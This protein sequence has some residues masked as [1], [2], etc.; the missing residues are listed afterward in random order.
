MKHFRDIAA[1]I[2]ITAHLDV[3]DVLLALYKSAKSDLI[4]WSWIEM[5]D[6]LGFGKTNIVHLFSLGKRP[7]SIKAG[8]KISSAVGWRGHRKAYW[9]ILVEWQA[10]RDPATREILFR[11][12]YAIR[13]KKATNQL[14]FSQYEYFDHW[15][16][17]AVR[18]LVA[19]ADF[20]SD[21]EW[22]A[23]TLI[24]PI[25]VDEAKK[26]LELLEGLNMIRFDE[27]LMRYV[28]TQE[29]VATGDNIDSISLVRYH[30]HMLDHAKDSITGVSEDLRDINAM[31]I[32]CDAKVMGEIK[33][34]LAMLRL[35]LLDL[36]EKNTTGDTVVQLNMQMFPLSKKVEPVVKNKE[37]KPKQA[38]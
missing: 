9:A 6:R 33:R 27:T 21:P 34:E 11:K 32:K 8:E 35:R 19:L 22:I 12:L 20:R 29:R 13:E 23:K 30:Q 5:A 10:E 28:V 2:D 16:Y 24:P 36:S 15:Y 31:T 14:N 37:S 4:S 25:R 7:L 18:E 38:R 3:R 1:S 17:P 26:S